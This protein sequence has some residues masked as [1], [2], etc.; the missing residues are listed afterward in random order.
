DWM[1]CAYEHGTCWFNG[2]QQVRFGETIFQHERALPNG[3]ACETSVFGNPTDDPYSRIR[4]CEVKL[5]LTAPSTVQVETDFTLTFANVVD[6]TGHE[7]L[8]LYKHGQTGYSAWKYSGTCD[9]NTG[10]ARSDGGCSFTVSD[11]AT[12]EVKLY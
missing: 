11:T 10:N 4:K 8:A 2:T 1:T 9:G 12:Y 7:W 3:T 5:A 6:P